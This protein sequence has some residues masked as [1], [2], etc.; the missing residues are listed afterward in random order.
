MSQEIRIEE[1]RQV[2]ERFV[3]DYPAASGERAIW[4]RPLLVSARAD[5]RF[6]ALPRMADPA[7]ALPEELLPR[8]RSV[9]VFFIP[10]TEELARENFGG[11]LPARSWGEAY[12]STNRLIGLASRH[13]EELLTGRGN[14]CALTPATHN[15]DPV[16]LTSRWSHKHLAYIAGLGRFGHHHLLITPAGCAGRFGSLVTSA[17][18]GDHPLVTQAETC[19]H[20]AGEECLRCVEHCPVGALTPQGFDRQRC[21]QRLNFNYHRAGIFQGL[22]DTTHVCAKCAMDLPC[23]FEIPVAA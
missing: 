9:I 21:W 2:L 14:A 3:A 7:H 15:F 6:Q 1:L 10:F 19:L 11:K 18:L 22:P 20:K 4:R 13:L 17:E 16:K 5:Q 23:S 8:A 12:V